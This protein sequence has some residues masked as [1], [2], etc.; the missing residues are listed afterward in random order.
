MKQKI[1]A[2]P[3]VELH[4]HLDGSISMEVASRLSSQSE[5]EV[6]S[7]MVASEKCE[8]LS[9]YLT[10]FDFPI[11]LMQSS[12]HLYEIAKSLVHHLYMENVIYA[13]VRFA[14]MFHR[15][16]GLSFEEIVE[17]V[18]RGL[19]SNSKVRV[20]LIL[21][22]MRGASR[23]DNLKTLEVAS[24]F[25]NR[26]VCAIDLAGDE[27]RFPLANY[28]ELF[29]IAR[30]KKIPFT[31]HAGENGPASE[32]LKAI[33]I[34]ASR[35]GHGI[36][37]VESKSLRDIIKKQDVLL[38][39]CPTSNVQTNAVSCYQ[40]HPIALFYQ[41]EVPISINTD[42]STVSNVTISD[43]YFKLYET[44]GFSLLDYQKMNENALCHAFL[45]QKEKV[46][47]LVVLREKMKKLS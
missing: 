24:Q 31:I 30:A 20:N 44:F 27:A 40:E 9:E 23:D 21:C 18:L 42:N 13:E 1:K 4:L 34:G 6:L 46:E 3:K 37:A 39:L 32:I 33:E 29:E 5:E 28:V 16:Q 12:D 14:P 36:S 11:S 35:I 41:E 38:E 7:Q 15:E 43:E 22:M 47:L 8:N 10:R 45:S 25:L 2:I 19:H 17:A 26:G